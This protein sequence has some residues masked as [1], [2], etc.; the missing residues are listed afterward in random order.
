M[1][2]IIADTSGLPAALD[3]SHPDHLA[4]GEALLAAGLLVMSPLLFAE[5]DRVATRGLGPDAAISAVDDAVDD[6]RRWM[7]ASPVA[8]PE[9]TEAHLTTAQSVRIR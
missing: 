5:I 3:S 9:I 6:I 8:V 2:T 1:I 4:A 7:R